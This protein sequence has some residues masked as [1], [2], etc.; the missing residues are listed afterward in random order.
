MDGSKKRKKKIVLTKIAAKETR[1][2]TENNTIG[3]TKQVKGKRGFR[4]KEGRGMPYS[5]GAGIAPARYSIVTTRRG[6]NKKKE[7]GPVL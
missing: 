6:K 3:D 1:A 2:Q 5:T 4:R 7:T